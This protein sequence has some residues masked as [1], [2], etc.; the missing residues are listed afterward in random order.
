MT[1]HVKREL[2]QTCMKNRMTSVA[3]ALAIAKP[4]S[5]CQ[6]PRSSFAASTVMNVSTISP[7]NTA[8]YRTGEVILWFMSTLSTLPGQ[9]QER[10]Q[11]NPDHIHEVPIQAADLDRR[12]VNRREPTPRGQHR[13]H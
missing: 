1:S 7:A 2:C 9:I 10:Q 3:F 5:T 4:T 8:R 11:E 12:V 6:W 13:Q